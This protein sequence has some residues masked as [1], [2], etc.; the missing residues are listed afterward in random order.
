V[1]KKFG[2]GD[3][4]WADF[5]PTQGHEQARKRP[6]LVLSPETYNSA[7]GLMIVCPITS[8]QKGYPFEVPLTGKISGVILADHIRSIDWNARSVVKVASAPK[9]VVARVSQLLGLL[10]PE[11]A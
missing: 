8:Q 5:T 11:T 7:S 4:V 9:H 1:E 3:I 2:R 6:A 10:L